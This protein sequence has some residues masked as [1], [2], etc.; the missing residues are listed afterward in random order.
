MKLFEELTIKFERPDWS[1]NPEFGLIDTILEKHPDILLL[2]KEDI[3][4]NSKD[5]P[6]GRGDVPSVE[7]IVRAAIYKEMK[8]MDYRELEYAQSDSRI[9]SNVIKK[10]SGNLAA[11]TI[12]IRMGS[13][14]ELMRKVYN[15]TYDHEIDGKQV[16]N[17][18][19]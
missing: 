14:L 2:M 5:S 19:K 1:R 3:A 6:F 8:G 10:K 16:R 15:M 17:E 12:L 4:G 9:C 13:L 7:Q 18:D 11:T